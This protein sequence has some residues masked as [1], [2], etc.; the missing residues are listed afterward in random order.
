M[1]LLEDDLTTFGLII[2]F[3]HIPFTQGKDQLKM[4]KMNKYSFMFSSNISL[5]YDGDC[6]GIVSM[7]F[8]KKEM[9]E[10]G[11]NGTI[12]QFSLDC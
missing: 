10:T 1:T 8:T 7:N 9:K 11:L 12:Y 4:F 2:S 3:L 5:H 6:L